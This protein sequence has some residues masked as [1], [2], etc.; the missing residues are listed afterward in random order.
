MYCLQT[1]NSREKASLS[2]RLKNR[3]TTSY[4]SRNETTNTFHIL[5]FLCGLETKKSRRCEKRKKQSDSKQ[6]KT[7]QLKKTKTALTKTT[8]NLVRRRN[9]ATNTSFTFLRRSMNLKER[10]SSGFDPKI[11]SSKS[12]MKKNSKE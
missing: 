10:K 3:Q 1:Q 11:T 8:K 9:S 7:N 12:H 5:I 6:S 2:S 4:K